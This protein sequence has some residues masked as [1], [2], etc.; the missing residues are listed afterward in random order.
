MQ[1]SFLKMIVEAEQTLQLLTGTATHEPGL[2]LAA[3]LVCK[4]YPPEAVEAALLACLP[5]GYSGNSAE[6][7]PGWV[8][9][10]VEKRA[11][12]DFDLGSDDDEGTQAFKAFRILLDLDVEFY[13]DQYAVRCAEFSF[14]IPARRRVGAISS[15]EFK[16]FIRRLFQTQT[17]K[18]I[19]P[20]ALIQCIDNIGARITEQGRQRDVFVRIGTVGDQT[21]I[22]LANDDGNYA[23]ISP[24]SVD[25]VDKPPIPMRG[26]GLLPLPDPVFA[27]GDQKLSGLSQFRELLGLPDEVWI[28]V[29]AFLLSALR[30]KGPYFLLLI[31][32]EQGSGKSSLSSALKN[33]VDPHVSDRT[34]LPKSVDDL[35]IYAQHTCLNVFDN[36]GKIND[37]ISDSLCTIST[38]GGIAKRKLYTDGEV[39]FI[40]VCRPFILNGIAG[41]VRRPDLIERSIAIN[42]KAMPAEN[43]LTEA[44]L[45]RRFRDLLPTV[46]GDLY[47]VLSEALELLP[48]TPVPQGIRMADAAQLLAAS[49]PALGLDRDTFLNALR[50]S[51]DEKML[52]TS[53]GNPT[54]Q[55]LVEI[56]EKN[57]NFKG[58]VSSLF[59]LF[60]ST[61]VADSDYLPQSASGLSRQLTILA[62]SLKVKGI[63]VERL[64]R[65]SSGQMVKLTYN[66]DK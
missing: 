11:R 26:G 2:S 57:P 28:K 59:D 39:Y 3:S 63:S 48:D 35:I 64:R 22:D 62:P 5:P 65:S 44:D 47:T 19:S 40:S 45:E 29:L 30:G 53:E 9:S 56:L 18:F 21:V 20:T 14:G 55:A 15:T 49:E 25:F 43:R 27:G 52:E 17:G 60:R 38:G 24:G 46:L 66:P 7:I 16:D 13:F 23:V 36:V 33:I 42:L 34:H 54:F 32:G 12:G 1:L 10:A 8:S 50:S 51:Q 41:V 37:T 61:T 31:E 58:T 6:E 4:N